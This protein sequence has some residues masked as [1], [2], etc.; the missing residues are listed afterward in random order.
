MNATGTIDKNEELDKLYKYLELELRGNDP[1]VL[2]SYAK[3]STTAGSLLDVDGKRYDNFRNFV[4][5]NL[6]ILN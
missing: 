4:M 5:D 6:N 2:R 3:F 1:A